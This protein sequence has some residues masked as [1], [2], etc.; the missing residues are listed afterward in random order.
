MT[1]TLKTLDIFPI[2]IELEDF[3]TYSITFYANSDLLSKNIF[4]S[5]SYNDEQE[6]N[7]GFPVISIEV[8]YISNEGFLYKCDVFSSYEY[9][10]SSLQ[11]D[12]MIIDL[13][14]ELK[15]HDNNQEIIQFLKDYTFTNISE[16]NND[17][18]S[19]EFKK[20][21]TKWNDFL[22]KFK[23]SSIKK[24]SKLDYIL[25]KLP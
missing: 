16:Y 17:T 3:Y 25:K 7:S 19:K 11:I 12:R 21:S 6:E 24:E 14:E 20:T 9:N 8:Y 1:K 22:E 10:V 18:N 5:S 15:L 13:V 4:I 23:K 2:K